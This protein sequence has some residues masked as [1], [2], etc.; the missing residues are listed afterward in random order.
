MGLI[1]KEDFS[2]V[3]RVNLGDGHVIR[4]ILYGRLFYTATKVTQGIYLIR[5]NYKKNRPEL[6]DVNKEAKNRKT[7]IESVGRTRISVEGVTSELRKYE[8]E[9]DKI[10]E[11]NK[12]AC[13]MRRKKK[14]I[15]EKKGIEELKEEV[16]VLGEFNGKG[17]GL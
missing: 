9:L 7:T 15:Q 11:R 3:M 16:L 2:K 17:R 6:I 1:N 8:K 5:F 4:G 13:E 10:Q 14:I 12:K